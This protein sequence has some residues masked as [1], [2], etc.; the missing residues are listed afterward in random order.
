MDEQTKKRLLHRGVVEVIVESEFLKRL[1]EGKPLRL[2]MGFD[3]SRAD[4]H[5]GHVVG[6]R[7][8]RQFQEEGHKVIL[9]VGD[10]TAQ[11][12]DPT[13]QSVTRPMLTAEAVRENAQSYLRQFFKVVDPDKTQVVWQS[14]WFGNFTLANIIKLTSYFTV[15][16][17]L[18]RE[19][20]NNR[21]KEGRPIAITELMYP[22]LQAYDSVAIESD[23]EF[24]GTDQK[25]NLLVGREL[26]E[27]MGHRRQQCLIMPILPGTDGV[28]KMSKSLDNYIAVEEAPSEMFGKVMSLP[29]TMIVPYMELLTDLP[30]AD[31][32]E[33]RQSIGA[34]SFNPMDAKKRLGAELVAIFHDSVAARQAREN[35]ER[36]VQRKEAPEEAGLV[37][38]PVWA[39][40]SP[41]GALW[42]DFRVQTAGGES[43]AVDM[44]QQRNGGPSVSIEVAEGSFLI[45]LGELLTK[46]GI[47]PSKGQVKR[48]LAQGG[49]EVDGSKV[50]SMVCAV[51]PGGLIKAGKRDYIR[52]AQAS[53]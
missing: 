1:D 41:E 47:A 49:I 11:I 20:F 2:K 15:A 50:E 25:F 48:L 51:R 21:F 16:Q 13:G 44:S 53:E 24:G 3:P 37:A 26:Q 18:A 52:I 43:F 34:P 12:G 17:F 31:I 42:P 10:W 35:F 4:I 30:A 39:S 8:L 19:D 29:D 40:G 5:L 22:L 23:V 46:G 28:R 7:K 14:E 38:T 45:D 27:K 36:V 33:I 6:L 32:E 9:I